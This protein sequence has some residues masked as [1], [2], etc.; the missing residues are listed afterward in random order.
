MDIRIDAPSSDALVESIKDLIPSPTPYQI[1]TVDQY[2]RAAEDLK[3]IKSR[4]KE[5]DDK[6]KEL[7]RPLDESKAAIMDLFRPAIELLKA[8]ENITKQMLGNYE[9]EQE[10]IRKEEEAR[11]AEIARKERERLAAEMRKTEEDTRAKAA[12]LARQAAE[13]KAAGDEGAE[14]RAKEKIA[15]AINKAVEKIDALNERAAQVI[16]PVVA[17]AVPKVAG[18]T[19]RTL[20]R[21][22]IVDANLIPDEYWM[23]PPIIEALGK[24]MDKF[25][26]TTQG[27]IQVPGVEFYPT[28][29]IGSTRT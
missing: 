27:A 25:A 24:C 16:A 19:S 17:S 4:I 7:T 28:K 29:S 9:A 10:R 6:R 14:A 12:E 23:Q 20:W 18:V 22:R 21:A 11:L 3:T 26:G 15:K 8:S 5:L 13:A 2:K 1:T